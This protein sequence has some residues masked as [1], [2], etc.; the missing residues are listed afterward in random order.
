VLRRHAPT[1]LLLGLG[2]G[3]LGLVPLHL[4]CPANAASHLILWHGL[5]PILAAVIA[6]LGWGLL[7]ER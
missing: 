6:G 1:G 4:H 7:R 2:A 5:V 3:L